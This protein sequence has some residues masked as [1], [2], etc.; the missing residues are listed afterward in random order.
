M[1]LQTL[2]FKPGINRESTSLGG[3]GGWFECDK[4]RFRSGVPEKI[5]GW[6]LDTGVQTGGLLPTVG[7]YWGTARELRTWRTLAGS[8]LLG[9]GTELKYYIQN[10][11]DGFLY[12]V[13]PI[14]ATTAAGA[15]T[16]AATTGSAVLTVTHASH[17]AQAGDFVTYSGAVSLGGVITAAVLNTEYRVT[18]VVSPGSYQI[19]ATVAANASDTTDGGASVVAQYQIGIGLS[20]TGAASGWGAGGWS[21]IPSGSSAAVSTL[22]GNITNSASSIVLVASSAFSATGTVV[23]GSE[24]ITYT[25][26]AANTLTGCVRGADGTTAVAH[27]SG[28]TVTQVLASFSGWGQGATSGLITAPLRLWSTAN[29]GQ[30]LIL[31]PR[32]GALYYWRTNANPTIFNRASLLT[33]QTFTI[34]LAAPGVVTFGTEV[35]PNNTRVTIST[36]GTLPTGLTAGSSYYIVNGVNLSATFDGSPITTS[37]SQS[38]VHTLIATDCPTVCNYVL[39]SDNSRFVLT[40]GVNDYNE[41]AQDPLLIRWSDQESYNTWFPQ[42]TNQA[43]SFRLSIGSEIVTAQ[44]TRQEVLVWTDAALYSMQYLGP[45]F[46]WGVQPLGSN[47]SIAGPNAA[48]TAGNVTYWMGNDKFYQYSGQVQTLPCTVWRYVFGDLNLTQRAQFFAS[49]N[50]SY[51]EVWWFY[52]SSNS[53]TVDRYVI[54]N[55]LE[56]VWMYGS[57]ARTAWIDSTLR[58][59]PTAA[60]YNGQILYHENGVDDGSTTPPSAIN[61]YV[62]SSDFDIGDGHNYGFVWRIIPDVTFDGSTSGAPQVMF[63]ALPRRNPGANYGTAANPVVISANNYAVQRNYLVQQF[64]EIVYTR[65]RGRQMAFKISSDQPGTQWQ[66]GAPRIDVRPD[67]RST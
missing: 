32:G 17:G 67:G 34:T 58:A 56:N 62:Q 9:V 10:S 29:F 21:G 25:G 38:G 7:A 53:N 37:V 19:T 52:C 64:T 33:Q 8:N 65:I 31:N 43:G 59:Y 60:G 39:V 48:T 11:A 16:F 63:A 14:R 5:G 42:A 66:F 47:I 13:T 24:S 49:T 18:S 1:P 46:V 28:A 20:V 44:Q 22:N 26:N 45:P 3:E 50:E 41:T 40:F 51:N 12:D 36:T 61:A 2:R 30:D 27:L 4:I 15:V 54:Y 35:L 6:T 57:M 23:I 55:Y